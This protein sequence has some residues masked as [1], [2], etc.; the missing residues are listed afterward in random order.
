MAK[1]EVKNHK[2]LKRTLIFTGVFCFFIILFVISIQIRGEN[3]INIRCSYLDPIT[4]DILAFS[5]ALFLIIEGF[6]RILE[7]PSATIKRQFTRTLR[8]A[9]GFSILT[10]HIMQFV[11][12]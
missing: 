5:A 2:N 6:A 1:K 4:I 8:I 12:K 11:H 9:F 7:H 3:I 10:L